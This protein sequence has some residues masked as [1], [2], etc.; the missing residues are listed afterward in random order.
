MT[1]S[2]K[3]NSTALSYLWIITNTTLE[4]IT[5][6]IFRFVEVATLPHWHE[7]TDGFFK[8]L[9]GD[10][11]NLREWRRVWVAN[12]VSSSVR[13]HIFRPYRIFGAIVGLH[14]TNIG[15][16]YNSDYLLPEVLRR[17]GNVMVWAVIT[18]RSLGPTVTLTGKVN[19]KVC[20]G[21]S[22]PFNGAGIVFSM[23]C[24]LSGW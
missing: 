20:E 17:E 21:I 22:C 18:L 7:G 14:M 9:Q 13:S 19:D 8:V 4:M 16:A 3:T 1:N 15:E 5:M 24:H 11:G 12:W 10:R 6:K 23:G 2:T